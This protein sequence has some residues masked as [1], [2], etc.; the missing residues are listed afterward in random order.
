ME[1]LVV[2][3]V[4]AIHICTF[5]DKNMVMAFGINRMS[6]GVN[7]TSCDGNRMLCDVNRMS[8]GVQDVKWC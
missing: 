4:D 8:C 5:R 2:L 3:F 6:C 1:S 7:K